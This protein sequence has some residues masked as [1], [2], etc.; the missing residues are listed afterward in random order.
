[1]LSKRGTSV[2]LCSHAEDMNAMS[3]AGDA[4]ATKLIIPSSAATPC[5][6]LPRPM[7][8]KSTRRGK[9]AE[10]VAAAGAT[11]KYVEM[12]ASGMETHSAA[13]PPGRTNTDSANE[14]EIG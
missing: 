4:A 14:S 1:M 7:L 10:R 8:F 13:E 9:S 12:S 11:R 3:S 6:L 5:A 2:A